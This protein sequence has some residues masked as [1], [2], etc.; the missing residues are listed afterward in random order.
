MSGKFRSFVIFAGMRTGSNLLEATLNQISRITCFGEA[1]NPY[2]LGWPDTDQILGV[3]QRERE[4][5]PLALLDKLRSR[6]DH[7]SGF[8]YF[9]DHD[10]RIFDAMMQDHTCAKVILTRNPLESYVSTRLAWETSQWKLNASETP[11]EMQIT[12]DGPEFRQTLSEIEAF[13]RRIIHG[14]QVSGQ[15]AFI[16]GY[17]D[18]R[19][20]D[21]LTG[22]VHWL[23]RR[24]VERVEP[25]SDQVPQNPQDM[26]SKVQNFDQMQA[27]LH[28]L[29]P[30]LLHHLPNYEP[31]RGPAVPS[32]TAAEVGQGLLYMPVRGQSND[33]VAA[34]LA[35]LGGVH[36]DFTQ[37]SLRQWKRNH[38]GHRSFTVLRH[39]LQRAWAAFQHLITR[40]QPDLRQ[41]MRDLYKVPLPPDA[42]LGAL[43]DDQNAALLVDFLGF[44]KRN[45]NGQTGVPV[46][47]FWAS[48]TEILA[49][50]AR[51]GSPDLL[52]REDRMADDLAHLASSA[53]IADPQ[54]DRLTPEPLPGFLQ[55]RKLIDA[56]YAA[57][58]RDYV[59]FGYEKT[60]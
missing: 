54:L 41:M 59:S 38:S 45:L 40:A 3:S 34:W 56:A 42:A 1:F 15:S 2:M 30:F 37:T 55:D 35:G 22:L 13:Q 48:Q 33:P 21:V 5:D 49:G 57:Y 7:L 26:A 20:G 24:D 14:L 19:D 8:R 28:Q 44:L 11:I 58:Q 25:A 27:D 31:R 52:V 60:P 32:F 18:L 9:H 29:D 43:H 51:F 10:A 16:L 39:P 23:G 53:G 47:P 36:G 50:F 12:Y 46:H 6:P 4:A 17:P